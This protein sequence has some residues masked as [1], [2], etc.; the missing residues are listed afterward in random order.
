MREMA[1]KSR[2]AKWLVSLSLTVLI[3]TGCG[4]E[5]FEKAEFA[6]TFVAN[7]FVTIKPKIDIVIFQD[8]SGSMLG[9]ANIFRAQMADFLSQVDSDWDVHLAVLPLQFN[10][11]NPTHNLN[12]RYIVSN[13]CSSINTFFC[14][15]PAQARTV[16]SSNGLVDDSLFYAASGLIGNADPGFGNMQ[17]QLQFADSMISTG[18]LRQDAML[19]VIPFTN[20]NDITGLIFPTDYQDRG[21]GQLE[22]NFNSANAA[23]SFATFY[24]F[25]VN[26]IKPTASLVNFFS[27]AAQSTGFCFG[28]DADEG[29][30]YNDMATAI[31]A[32]NPAATNGSSFDICS[33]AGLSAAMSNIAIQLRD[34]I[35]TVEFNFIAIPQRPDPATI[36]ILKNGVEI[37]ANNNVNGWTLFLGSNG[38]HDFETNVPTSFAPVPGNE[39]SGFMIQLHG[40]AVFSGSDSIE[41]IYEELL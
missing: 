12:N 21:D 29:S 5:E 14:I 31:N 2:F 28:S 39:R 15:T 6:E 4:K 37:P 33:N 11:G 7:Q 32:S 41:V 24:N 10:P 1:K 22:P 35:L 23:A 3:F 13:D 36:R 34:I 40:S 18:F 9:P 20:G 25:L 17:A 38:S 16:I 27:V 8:I 30:R 19:A 26:Q